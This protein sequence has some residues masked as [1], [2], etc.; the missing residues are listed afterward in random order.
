MIKFG[1]IFMLVA[2][3]S[4]GVFVRVVVSTSG[5][6]NIRPPLGIKEQNEFDKFWKMI[7]RQD[8]QDASKQGDKLL[9]RLSVDGYKKLVIDINKLIEKEPFIEGKQKKLYATFILL[10]RDRLYWQELNWWAK[11]SSYNDALKKVEENVAGLEEIFEQA[12]NSIFADMVLYRIGLSY[13][14]F[15]ELGLHGYEK[16]IRVFNNIKKLYPRSALVD[17]ADFEIINTKRNSLATGGHIKISNNEI[18]DELK[19][20]IKKYPNS[21]RI[22]EAHYTLGTVYWLAHDYELAVNEFSDIIQNFPD[23]KEIVLKSLEELAFIYQYDLESKEKEQK[24]LQKIISEFQ[25][26][27]E[28]EK[29]T[30]R[31]NSLKQLH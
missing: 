8:F 9:D 14:S 4:L 17:D 15:G 26:S 2:V 23:D 18:I 12:P 6:L 1:F 20:F 19:N 21:N 22:I 16:A 28:A 10:E 31:F 25:N 7:E 11:E 3:L 24:V 5:K 29:A 30:S 27:A 13:S